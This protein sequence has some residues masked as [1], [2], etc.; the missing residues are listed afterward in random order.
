MKITVKPVKQSSKAIR[1]SQAKLTFNK[2]HRVFNEH[3][4]SYAAF[5]LL[6]NAMVHYWNEV[7]GE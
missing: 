2:A 6:Q 4:T 5:N 1:V 3:P 7:N